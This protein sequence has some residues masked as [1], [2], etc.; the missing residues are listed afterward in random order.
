MTYTNDYIR[1]E[2]R[3]QILNKGGFTVFWA[4][5]N[6]RRARMLDEMHEAGEIIYSDAPFP[7]INAKLKGQS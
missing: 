2:I 4:T 7:W 5:E 6:M 1:R 3:G